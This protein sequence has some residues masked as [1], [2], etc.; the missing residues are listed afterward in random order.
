MKLSDGEKLI[1]LMLCDMYKAMKLK[2]EFDPCFIAIRFTA[3]ICGGSDWERSGIPFEH[4][5]APREVRETC[6]YLEMW[7]FLESGYHALSEKDKE[8]LASDLGPFGKSVKFPGFDGKTEPHFLVAH[9]INI[10]HGFEHFKRT[11]TQFASSLRRR[12]RVCP[13]PDNR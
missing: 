2:G 5:E 3:A 10:R 12:I 11:S 9:Y 8:Q 6:D 7:R 13:H 4:S 1:L